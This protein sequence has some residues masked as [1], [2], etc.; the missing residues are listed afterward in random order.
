MNS[1]TTSEDVPSRSPLYDLYPCD[2]PLM[3]FGGWEM[4]RDFGGIMEEHRATRGEVGVFDLSH[5]GRIVIKGPGAASEVGGWFTRDVASAPRKRA[6]YGF[7]CDESGGCL[8]DDILYKRNE[9]EVWAVINAAN[10]DVVVDHLRE[11]LNGVEVMDCTEVTVLLAIQGPEAPELIESLELEFFPDKPFRAEWTDDDGMNATTGYTGEEG[12]EIWATLDRGRELF[13]DI[14]DRDI[15][16]CGLGARDTLRLEQGYPL[17]GHELS[18]N[19]DPVTAGL[20][21]FIDWGHDFHGKFELETIKEQGPEQQIMGLKLEGR[22]SPRQGYEVRDGDSVVGEVTS[23]RF[24]PSLNCGIGLAL[25]DESLT[26]QN[27]VTVRIRDQSFSAEL[28]HPPFL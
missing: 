18:E 12:G 24:S 5:M 10:R 11:H 27:E 14:I 22:R 20:E 21:M 23:G 3:P 17:H 19:I 13:R 25:V 8:D 2:P 28:V 6:L 15:T 9:D 16:L 7:F 26:E 4:P 1:K